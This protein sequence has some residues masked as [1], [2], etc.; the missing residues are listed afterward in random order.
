MRASGKS[1]N[2]AR[3]WRPFRRIR[4]V[5]SRLR[6]RI[7]FALGL[8]PPLANRGYMICA[9]SR[10]GSTY[11]CQLLASTDLLGKPLEYFNTSGRRERNDS[12]YPSDRLAQLDIIRTKGAT[13]NGIYAVKV[14]APQLQRLKGRVDPFRDLPNLALVRIRRVDVL[15]QAISLARARQTGQFIASDRQRESPG[16][17]AGAIRRALQSIAEQETMW[18][19]TTARLGVQ[20]LAITYEDILSDPQAVVDRI[21][22]VVGLAM[23]VPLARSLV[24]HTM[25]RDGQS[26]EWRARFLAESGD[27]FRHLADR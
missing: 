17:D 3:R 5:A 20:P 11:L 25:Q 22:S 7:T 16:Y 26:A 12:A 1:R 24:T 6:R 27:E 15:G 13:A 21:A 8:R 18:D 9:T 23:P 2:P 19:A 4:K 14:I 10:T